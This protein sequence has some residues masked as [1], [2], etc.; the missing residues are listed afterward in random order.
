MLLLCIIHLIIIDTLHFMKF[1]KNLVTFFV[2]LTL[3]LVISTPITLKA[4]QIQN[5]SIGYFSSLVEV[6]QSVVAILTEIKESGFAKIS[7]KSPLTQVTLSSAQFGTGTVW[8]V[9]PTRQYKKPS[10]VVALVQD[11]DTVE[12]DSAV[13][14][15]DTSVKWRAN[16]LTLRGV[17]GRPHLDA[18]GCPISGG[19]AIWNP[20]GKSLLIDN[21]EFSGADVSDNNGAGIRYDGGGEV[22]VRN[23]YF[24]DN[25]NGI[26]FTPS[27][28]KYNRDE[29][30]L[31]IEYSKFSKNGYSDGKSHNFYIQDIGKFT[32]R[33]NISE[34]SK[35][36]HLVKTRAK[37]NF[38]LYNRLTQLDGTGSY[39]ID[40]SNGGETYIIGN[41]IQQGAKS[42]NR[43]IVA[44]AGEGPG[45]VPAVG[46]LSRQM[47]L[48]FINN[49]II[50]D[51]PTRSSGINLFDHGITEAVIANNLVTGIAADHFI[52]YRN[53][54]KNTA[55]STVLL[56]NIIT[57]SPGF[58]DRNQFSYYLTAS[59]PAIDAGIDIGI[60]NS[61]DLKASQQYIHEARVEPRPINAAIDAGAYEY[62]GRIILK[63]TISLN[64]NSPQIPYNTSATVSWSSENTLS[65]TASGA[66]SGTK[67]SSGQESVGPFTADAKF[68]LSCAGLGGSIETEVIL[69]VNPNPQLANYPEYEFIQLPNTKLRSICNESGDLHG[70][71]GCNALNGHLTATYDSKRNTV[72]FWQGGTRNYWGNGVSSLNLDTKTIAR[73][74]EPTEPKNVVGYTGSQ[75][76]MVTPCN[77]IWPLA[78]GSG[79][80]PAPTNSYSSFLYLPDIDRVASLGGKV[81]CGESTFADK[82]W[83]FDPST[84][85]WELKYETSPVFDSGANGF[86]DTETNTI[87]LGNTKGIYRYDYR[88]N[89]FYSLGGATPLPWSVGST[90]DQRNKLWLFLGGAGSNE[91]LPVL[92]ISN[93]STGPLPMY[94]VNWKVFG[95]TQIL[96]VYSP[97]VAYDSVNKVVVAWAG[98]GKIYFIEPDKTAKTVTILP[99]PIRNSPITN[100]VFAAHK[101]MYIP[102]LQAFLVFAGIDQDMYLLKATGRKIDPTRLT[103]TSSDLPPAD[104]S[105]VETPSSPTPS[106]EDVVPPSIPLGLTVSTL[107]DRAVSLSWTASTDNTEV[108]G[109]R[110]YR[111]DSQIGRSESPYYKDRSIRPGTEYAYAV[112]AYDEKGNVSQKSVA[113]TITT[114][115]FEVTP[116][117]PKSAQSSNAHSTTTPNANRTEN[118]NQI[119]TGSTTPKTN[120]T[121]SRRSNRQNTSPTTSDVSTGGSSVT[122][123][124]P[125]DASVRS[126]ARNIAFGSKG[127]DV[128]SLQKLL[129]KNGYL[130]AENI[131]GFFGSATESAVKAFQ[132][133]NNIVFGGDPATTGY[134]AAGPLT[135]NKINALFCSQTTKGTESNSLPIKKSTKL[136]MPSEETVSPST[137][138]SAPFD[139]TKPAS[140]VKDTLLNRNIALGTRGDDVTKL[141][142]FL[143]R[144]GYLTPDNLTGY[145]GY[146]TQSAVGNLQKSMNIVSAGTPDSTGY[147]AVGPTTRAKINILL[148]MENEIE[149]KI[150]SR[151]EQIATL[152]KKVQELL[153]QLKALQN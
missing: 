33:Y 75:T 102:S 26:L 21:I 85:K 117:T 71:T 41:I 5:P 143:V 78:N 153:A 52:I 61:I 46:N 20:V 50:N 90:V 12:I 19:K 40:I 17:G 47:K 36:G 22:I 107:E 93:L 140:A 150:L 86:L 67:A 1:N 147:G 7:G 101:F 59:S 144:K 63:P 152:L 112:V 65:C 118:N 82:G 120:K 23:S 49:T 83:F 137:P 96:K 110:I 11:G 141:Q 45:A 24:H 123:N 98:D 97:G 119:E 148:E 16:N 94:E 38:I 39:E 100:N 8:Q 57:E 146:S 138:S 6:L 142:K 73:V 9:G 28:A 151:E 56:N 79:T 31:L 84:S 135:R 37:Q 14:K 76:N 136:V 15:C 80:V 132:R 54:E 27:V 105:E 128:T 88:A 129:V 109:Y 51:H 122:L 4:E 58:S 104:E 72:Y 130:T 127:T 131:T 145:F 48:Y 124:C 2:S 64:L 115:S 99:H 149:R 34:S 116:A 133:D 114:K 139:S 103:T 95:D 91:S 43:G 18:K 30:S 62:D 53:P 44:Y 29:V 68:S 106:E 134:G 92:D 74:T 42:E 108:Q 3:V 89:T 13:Y 77:G 10:D 35:V 70:T 32:F 81:A 111:N 125:V 113:V 66:W 55:S 69:S 126:F 25:E 87:I 121:G 60:K